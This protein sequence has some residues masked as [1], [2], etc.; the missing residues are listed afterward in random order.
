MMPT[1][2]SA[3][4]WII[5]DKYYR[6]GRNVQVGDVVSFKSPIMEG[7]ANIKRVIGM[8]GDFVLMNTPGRS[9]AMI[10]V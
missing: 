4:E 10:Q 9:D 7:E 5:L 2:A 6:R 8:A 1:F 3:G